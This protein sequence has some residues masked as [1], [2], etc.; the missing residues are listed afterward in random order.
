MGLDM[1]PQASQHAPL[2]N[3]PPSKKS[4]AQRQ[5]T[6]PPTFLLVEV[7]LHG[8]SWL[9]FADQPCRALHE[10]SHYV[11]LVTVRVH[12]T[13][14]VYAVAHALAMP[15]LYVGKRLQQVCGNI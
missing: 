13:A 15:L 2:L 3:T 4:I 1:A 10:G 8:G 14:H 7:E 11:A 9:G 6:A 12:A 5:K